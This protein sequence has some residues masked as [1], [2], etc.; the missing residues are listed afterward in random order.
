VKPNRILTC[1]LLC[2]FCSVVAQVTGVTGDSTFV[3][4][5]CDHE[6][7]T[8]TLPSKEGC[9]SYELANTPDGLRLFPANSDS[10]GTMDLDRERWTA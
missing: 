9:V 5:C 1:R 8:F 2:P 10:Y 7:T 6:R 4:L 3:R